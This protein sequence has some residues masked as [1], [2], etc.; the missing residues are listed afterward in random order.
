VDIQVTLYIVVVHYCVKDA[1]GEPRVVSEAHIGVSSDMHHDT[2]FVQ[3][4]MPLLAENLKSRGLEFDVWNINTDGAASH[5][6]NRYTFF[7]LFQFQRTVGASHVMWETCA[8]GHGKGP[9]DGIGAVIKRIL[10]SLE[11][12]GK[13][14]ALTPYDVFLALLRW[15]NQWE[16]DLSSRYKLSKFIFHYVPIAGEKFQQLAPR[17]DRVHS[18]IS[19]PKTPP[20]TT[21]VDGCRSHFSFRVAGGNK[22]AIRELSCRCTPCLDHDWERCENQSEVGSWTILYLESHVP[23][24]AGTK[25]RNQ[26]SLIS[27]QRRALAM[28]CAVGEFVAL[29]SAD[30][31]EGFAFW[32]ALVTKAAWIRK[33]KAPSISTNGNKLVSG[34]CYLEVQMFHRYP[35]TCPRTFQEYDETPWTV[36]AEAVVARGIS[37]TVLKAPRI[38]PRRGR[39]G[40]ECQIGG[41]RGP[42]RISISEDEASR[43]TSACCVR[44]GS[45][46]TV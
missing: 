22:L 28:Q 13:V 38:R 35:S 40:V 34:H 39:I 5:F 6:K 7:S 12:Q 42:Q 19:R 46:R 2:H 9:W 45:R 24:S 8:P 33:E 18:P 30:D 10:R 29:E 32:I 11:V 31:E 37:T 3:H 20:I 21:A 17:P 16:T 23:S 27:N 25:T 26:L 36:D 43:L 41:R 15:E 1:D 14:V 44:L 4:F